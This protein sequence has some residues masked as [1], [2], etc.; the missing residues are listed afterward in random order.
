[1]VRLIANAV[2][3]LNNFA[4]TF[5]GLVSRVCNSFV[6]F[7]NLSSFRNKSSQRLLATFAVTQSD[8]AAKRREKK[9]MFGDR[10][11]VNCFCLCRWTKDGVFLKL[12]LRNFIYTFYDSKAARKSWRMGSLGSPRQLKIFASLSIVNESLRRNL[13][14][15]WWAWFVATRLFI[16]DCW[17]SR[18]YEILLSAKPASWKNACN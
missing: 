13:S 2:R 8:M 12:Q 6:S 5:D 17:N 4:E 9:K 11:S 7:C 1:M 16:D 18:K 15:F 3:W 10:M 14:L